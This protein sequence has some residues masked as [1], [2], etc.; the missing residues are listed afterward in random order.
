MVLPVIALV[1]AADQ[2][3]DLGQNTAAKQYHDVQ[4]KEGLYSISKQYGVSIDQ[5]K[6][7]NNLATN[8]LHVGQQLVIY[9]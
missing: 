9:K 3:K 2:S 1:V 4:P 6:E 5:L 7:W 8:D